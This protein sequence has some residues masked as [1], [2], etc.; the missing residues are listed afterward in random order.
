[1][2]GSGPLRKPRYI[3]AIRPEFPEACRPGLPFEAVV[4]LAIP[5]NP[6]SRYRLVCVNSF[7]LQPKRRYLALGSSEAAPEA[8]LIVNCRLPIECCGYQILASGNWQLAIG[9]STIR[10]GN[11]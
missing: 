3:P 1:M 9:S 2:C 11:S 6:T 10:P 7:R 5:R 8:S 4:T